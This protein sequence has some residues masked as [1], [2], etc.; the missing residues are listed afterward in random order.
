M[1]RCYISYWHVQQKQSENAMQIL[2]SS[3]VLLLLSCANTDVVL[4]ASCRNSCQ[5]YS[6]QVILRN[7]WVPMWFLLM[8]CKTSFDS[9]LWYSVLQIYTRLQKLMLCMSHKTTIRLVD[10]MG[11]NHDSDVCGWRDEILKTMTQPSSVN[12]IAQ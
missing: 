7:K 3:L 12:Y 11:K 4:W 9:L 5:L 10:Q 6:T 8:C 2:K 1:L